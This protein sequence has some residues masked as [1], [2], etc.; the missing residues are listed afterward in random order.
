MNG[1]VAI[2][3]RIFQSGFSPLKISQY[4]L[5]IAFPAT[6]F[7]L[8]ILQPWMEPS[9]LITD[10]ISAAQMVGAE[11]CC[12]VY[13][14]ALSN[15][16]ILNWTVAAGVSLFTGLVLFIMR[17]EATLIRF[18][19]LSGILTGWFALDDMY[20]FHDQFLPGIGVNENFVLLSYALA[21]LFYLLDS[22][23][24]I[25]KTDYVLFGISGFFLFLS[26]FSDVLRQVIDVTATQYLED[27]SKVI[28]I[29]CWM[30]YHISASARAI[31][32]TMK[33]IGD[34]ATPLIRSD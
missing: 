1:R 11:R 17:A 20:L 27:A 28:G 15:F 5:T 6:L 18:L 7:V 21:A 12:S 31:L 25:L 23:R 19:V 2:A 3:E 26:L 22:R 32:V 10:V 29:F 4:V 14:G 8:V 9:L 16:G 24:E 13:F 34:E 33:V 30:T